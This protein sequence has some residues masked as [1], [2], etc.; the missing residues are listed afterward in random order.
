MD[1]NAIT[2][3][4]AF[5]GGGFEFNSS[6]LLTITRVDG[7]DAHAHTRTHTY[8]KFITVTNELNHKFTFVTPTGAG[9]WHS[10]RALSCTPF[11]WTT[12]SL[13]TLF[14]YLP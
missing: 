11:P 10:A 14:V 1:A 12:P 9:I 2:F 13:N 5:F 4:G 6:L 8:T 7:D 3:F